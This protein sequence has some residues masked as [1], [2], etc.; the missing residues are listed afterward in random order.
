MLTPLLSREKKMMVGIIGAR[1]HGCLSTGVQYYNFFRLKVDMVD[2]TLASHASNTGTL[3]VSFFMFP[4]F[5]E[6]NGKCFS[7]LSSLRTRSSKKF[8]FQNFLFALN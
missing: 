3:M 5:F 2:Y 4:T 6:T 8:L 1:S 7:Q